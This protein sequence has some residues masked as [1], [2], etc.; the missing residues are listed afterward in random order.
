MHAW[1]E[2]EHDLIYKPENGNVSDDEEAILD[3]VNGLVLTGEVALEGLQRALQRRLTEKDAPFD[4]HYDLAA[5]LHRW[6]QGAEPKT[7]AQ[8]GRV[9]LLWELLREAQLN[10]AT[11]LQEE[12]GEPEVLSNA[13]SV[14]DQLADIILQKRP[15]LYDFYTDLLARLN[16]TSGYDQTQ[17][18]AT[19]RS[20]A[21]GHFLSAWIILER[22]HALNDNRTALRQPYRSGDISRWAERIGLS[23]TSLETIRDVRRI[24]N[25][26][27][28]GIEIPSPRFL[29]EATQ[30]LRE[31]LLEIENHH[32]E[33]VR[34]SYRDAQQALHG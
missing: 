32:D 21:I 18:T 10:S 15:K 11:K 16:F 26:V 28:H 25:Q 34:Q 4:S 24:R 9:D 29:D 27:V 3:E 23:S 1:A 5:Y 14:S 17:P 19:N 7:D 20:Q 30:R 12:V 6:L 2:I 8:M 13:E 22:S 33:R 31:V